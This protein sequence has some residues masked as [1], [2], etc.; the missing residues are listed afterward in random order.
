MFTWSFLWKF[1]FTW[2]TVEVFSG[3]SRAQGH[4]WKIDRW[5][6]VR[7]SR[8]KI[9]KAGDRTLLQALLNNIGKCLSS[10]RQL[11]LCSQIWKNRWKKIC[12]SWFSFEKPDSKPCLID[13]PPMGAGD[14]LAAMWTT[15]TGGWTCLGQSYTLGDINCSI[16]PSRMGR[17]G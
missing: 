10:R 15:M 13:W 6:F 11:P 7:E 12:S 4:R 2:C 9:D 14:L 17:K 3:H 16:L 1:N 8:D 5:S